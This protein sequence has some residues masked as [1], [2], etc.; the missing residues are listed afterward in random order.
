MQAPRQRPGGYSTI[1]P[2]AANDLAKRLERLN[3]GDWTGIDL[4]SL[5]V[6]FVTLHRGQYTLNTATPN[7]AWFA[8]LGLARH[9]WR[10][11]ARGG[12]VTLWAPG[13]G[14][15]STGPGSS[16]PATAPSSARAG[17]APTAAACR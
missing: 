13:A 10:K 7:R 4:A 15:R 9:G 14:R 3:C 1:A 6:R 16:R 12:A 5:G 2:V 17:T 8:S 11:V